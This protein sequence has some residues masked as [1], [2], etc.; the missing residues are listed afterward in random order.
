MAGHPPL[1]WLKGSSSRRRVAA[2]GRTAGDIVARLRTSTD[3][4]QEHIELVS[5]FIF[6]F[7]SNQLK[8]GA[9]ACCQLRNCT[10]TEVLGRDKWLQIA[11]TGFALFAEGSG[12]FSGPCSFIHN[13]YVYIM[14][15]IHIKESKNLAGG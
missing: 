8:Y 9:A 12:G 4:Q 6:L 7:T 1:A 10:L 15:S 2:S 3:G 11:V 14:T 5:H 13:S